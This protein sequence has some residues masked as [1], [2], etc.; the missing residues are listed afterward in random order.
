[1]KKLFFTAA[2]IVASAT[3][4]CAENGVMKEAQQNF[5]PIPHKAW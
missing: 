5:K 1:M 3:L 4:A 2:L